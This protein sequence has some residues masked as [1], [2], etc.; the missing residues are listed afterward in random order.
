MY[1][2]EQLSMISGL[3]TRTLRNY[4]KAGILC[5]EKENGAW[6]FTEEQVQAFLEHPAVRPS[7]QAK[8]QA[9]VYDFLAQPRKAADET[10]I[11]MDL[12]LDRDEAKE[13]SNF[14]CEEMK[15]C[16][17][18]RFAFSYQGGMARI[19]LSGSQRQVRDI[20]RRY[21]LRGNPAG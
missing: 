21:D 9:I 4:L 11:I 13:V 3:T 7:I 19:F 8:H 16:E 18:A 20:M 15:Q 14:F 5:G 1:H 6:T 12:N 2:M 10:C 17:K